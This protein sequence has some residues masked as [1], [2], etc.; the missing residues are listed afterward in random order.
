MRL[1]T[2]SSCSTR[3]R[4]PI[5]CSRRACVSCA[6]SLPSA[7]SSTIL[8]LYAMDGDER[9]RILLAGGCETR[10]LGSVVGGSHRE[11]A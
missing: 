11:A 4:S 8:P 3:S 1:A 10:D 5:S 7:H 6:I 9:I 2:L